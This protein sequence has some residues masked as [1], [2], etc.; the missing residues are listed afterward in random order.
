MQR[1]KLIALVLGAVFAIPPALLALYVGWLEF[2]EWRF[3]QGRPILNAMWV[4]HLQARDGSSSVV[5][6]ETLLG[7]FPPGSDRTVAAAKLSAEGFNCLESPVRLGAMDCQLVAPADV[8][9]TRWIIDLYANDADELSFARV[10]IGG[11]SF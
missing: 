6:A 1:F 3:Y 11:I 10:V 4:A 9:Y 8:G 2:D 5:A 7:V